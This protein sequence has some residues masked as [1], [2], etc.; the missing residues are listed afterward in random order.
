M[1]RQSCARKKNLWDAASAADAVRESI[2]YGFSNQELVPFDWTAF[3]KRSDAFV[4]KVNNLYEDQLRS[5]NVEFIQGVATFID[6]TTIAIKQENAIQ[7]QISARRILIAVGSQPRTSKIENAQLGITSDGFF[8]VTEQPKKVAVVG[9]GYIAVEL[10]GTLHALGADTHLFIREESLLRSFDPIIQ[11]TLLAEYKRQ[12]IHIHDHSNPR[13]I[14]GVGQNLKRVHYERYAIREH[15]DVDC[16]VWAIGRV[17]QIDALGVK[18]AGIEQNDKGE[19]M[20]NEQWES[21]APNIYAVGDIC[22]RGNNLTP[23]AVAAGTI[24]NRS[25]FG[26][27]E[28]MLLVDRFVPSVVFAHPPVGTIGLT[29]TKARDTYGADNIQVIM[30]RSTLTY[31]W[32]MMDEKDHKPTVYKIICAG[33]EQKV[34]GLHIIGRRADELLQGFAVAMRSGAT[35][36]DF[37]DT[38]AVHPTASEELITLGKVGQ[39]RLTGSELGAR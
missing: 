36:R 34:V 30:H 7:R 33:K 27:F 13:R 9:E 24:L 1:N 23:V 16:L 5:H 15:L 35:L 32:A 29:E 26:G 38:L 25:L 12:G 17:P 10:A 14:E 18:K 11:D 37:D 4:R 39:R 2:A 19:I 8:N 22:D 31:Y 6:R 20:V 28:P 3:K 21:S